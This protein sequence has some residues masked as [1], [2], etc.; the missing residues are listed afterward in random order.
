[1]KAVKQVEVELTDLDVREY[2]EKLKSPTELVLLAH[3]M[4]FR[5]NETDAINK[6]AWLSVAA[7]VEV[8]MRA[9]LEAWKAAPINGV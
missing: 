2:I 1:M 5:L 7:T 3:K 4:L 9:A 8:K 6:V